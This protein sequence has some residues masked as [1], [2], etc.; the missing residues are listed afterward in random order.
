MSACSSVGP[1]S[2]TGPSSL[3]LQYKR[4]FRYKDALRA[5]EKALELDIRDVQEVYS[6]IGVLYSDMR[7]A[8][9]AREMYERSL[10]VDADY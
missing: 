9:K 5:Y 6:N 1:I 10:A 3:A 2:Q 8:E 7:D 4:A